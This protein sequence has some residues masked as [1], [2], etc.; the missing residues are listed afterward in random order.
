MFRR[1]GS[2]TALIRTRCKQGPRRLA[3]ALSAVNQLPRSIRAANPTRSARASLAAR[4][5]AS[6]A[7]S[8]AVRSVR[9][10]SGGGWTHRA[11]SAGSRCSSA[12]AR[13][14]AV[15]RSEPPSGWPALQQ[16][17]RSSFTAFQAFRNRVLFVPPR[18]TDI[19]AAILCPHSAHTTE[20]ERMPTERFTDA[21]ALPAILHTLLSPRVL[22]GFCTHPAFGKDA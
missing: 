13:G 15:V 1:N 4:A 7:R 21:L 16:M 10:T 3:V 14:R 12:A 2:D 9:A 18:R 17:R 11:E 19:Q 5:A 22:R 20:M 8:P 6:R